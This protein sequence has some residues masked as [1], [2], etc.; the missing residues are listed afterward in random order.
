MKNE[1]LLII[2]IIVYAVLLSSVTINSGR[3][4]DD[5]GNHAAAGLLVHDVVIRLLSDPLGGLAGIK[6]YVIMH[7]AHYKSFASFMTYGPLYMGFI[8]MCYLIFGAV[9]QTAMLA[10]IFSSMVTLY[11]TYMLSLKCYKNKKSALLTVFILAFSPLFFFYSASA[12][13]EAT[14]TMFLV[15]TAYYFSSYISEKKD[16]DL[17]LSAAGAALAILTK[18]PMVLILPVLVLAYFWERGIKLPN[19]KLML[20]NLCFCLMQLAD[21]LAGIWICWIEF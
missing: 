2:F 14:C 9:R 6:E 17:Y 12:F 20:C 7:H 1:Q 13:M 19:K 18:P 10:A 16:A 4:A 3:M 21:C 5:Q 8:G 11:F 15:I